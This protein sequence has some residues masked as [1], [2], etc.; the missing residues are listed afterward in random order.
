MLFLTINEDG[1]QEKYTTAISSY[2]ADNERDFIGVQ[3]NFN[4]DTQ[5]YSNLSTARHHPWRHEQ[6]LFT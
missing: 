5:L 3:E 2:L 1:P 4:Y 6:L